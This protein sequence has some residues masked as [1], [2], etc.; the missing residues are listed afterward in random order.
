[1]IKRYECFTEWGGTN[2]D[3]TVTEG[4][5]WV[6]YEDHAEAM[7][8]L[9]QTAATRERMNAQTITTLRAEVERLNAI[10]NTQTYESGSR[11]QELQGRLQ[12]ALWF[13]EKA[14]RERDAGA[15]AG[16]AFIVTHE[17]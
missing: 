1:M 10:V 9:W 14:E 12:A 6:S 8:K 16:A 11:I 5:P 15:D 2:Y 3:A 7:Q 13:A 4:G 17:G